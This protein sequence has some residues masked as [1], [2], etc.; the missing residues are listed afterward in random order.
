MATSLSPAGAARSGEGILWLLTASKHPN[1][2]G[3]SIRMVRTSGRTGR[4][5][6]GETS[7][8]QPSRCH[9]SA[10]APMGCALFV[11]AAGPSCL[12]TFPLAVMP[13]TQ[14]AHD[15]TSEFN[16]TPSNLVN[17]LVIGS[18]QAIGDLPVRTHPQI[19]SQNRPLR[20]SYKQS[21]P[22]TRT[23][24]GTEVTGPRR[25][26]ATANLTIEHSGPG[27]EWKWHP[28]RPSTRTRRAP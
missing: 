21:A 18:R 14:L 15:F 2:Q 16:G 4:K 7:R 24:R 10:E 8:L 19:A 6:R 23:E 27:G 11:V 26:R 5:C 17:N 3:G 13:V 1:K 25:S 9:A 28:S 20:S 12:P 22:W